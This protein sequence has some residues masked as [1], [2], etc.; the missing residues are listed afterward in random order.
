MRGLLLRLSKLDEGAESAVRIISYFDGLTRNHA[1]AD[2][3]VRAASNLAECSA[4]MR[5]ANGVTIAFSQP[6]DAVR[7][8]S[9]PTIVERSF[10]SAAIGGVVW[11]ERQGE[12][13]PLDDMV[14]ERMAVAAEIVLERRVGL[15]K[16]KPE[17]SVLIRTLVNPRARGVDRHEAAKSLGL[18]GNLT[19]VAVSSDRDI[20]RDRDLLNRLGRATGTVARGA[21]IGERLSS[22]V[23]ASPDSA[24]VSASALEAELGADESAGVAGP[25]PVGDAPDTWS[26]ARNALRFTGVGH[27]RVVHNSELGAL[28]VLAE[29]EPGRAQSLSDVVALDHIQAQSGGVEAMRTL[30]SICSTGSIRK[31][32]AE[33]HLH[34]SSV[35]ARIRKAEATLGFSVENLDGLFRLSLALKLRELNLPSEAAEN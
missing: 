8:P 10:G 26:R 6:P 33:L 13:Q 32:S 19:M 3:L 27:G 2:V 21:S 29:V 30:S 25:A 15:G 1:S 31:T 34:H 22:L 16:S 7:A 17:D 18:Q 20:A 11:L 28:E 5:D 4:G 9:N 12:A 14:L 24:N 23:L 35:V